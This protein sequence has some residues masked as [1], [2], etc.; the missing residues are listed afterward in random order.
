MSSTMLKLSAAA[1]IIAGTPGLAPAQNGAYTVK[2]PITITSFHINDSYAFDTIG[3][4]L[5]RA[6][7]LVPSDFSVKFIN[8]G[9]VTATAVTFSIDTGR[10]NQILVD[11]G[12]FSRGVPIKRDFSIADGVDTLSSATCTV[13]EV[14]FADGSV[15]QAAPSPA[16]GM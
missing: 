9:N 12:T 4:D 13:T 7:Q 11:K 5:D 10:S 6:P 2:A 3:T 15:W 14:D 16:A 1:A 8:T